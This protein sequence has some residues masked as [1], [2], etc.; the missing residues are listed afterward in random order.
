MYL[1]CVMIGLF[2]CSFAPVVNDS[3]NSLIS[4]LHWSLLKGKPAMKET[5]RNILIVYWPLSNTASSI[6]TGSSSLALS[7]CW[8][9]LLEQQKSPC[10]TQ[11]TGQLLL[12]P[13]VSVNQIYPYLILFTGI[14]ND[15]ANNTSWDGSN[16]FKAEERIQVKISKGAFFL[17]NFLYQ[18]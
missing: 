15:W 6:P 1:I 11:F 16:S 18:L 4:W 3:G 12:F 10:F 9:S 17:G 7:N 5:F 8:R 2:D 14:P 13:T